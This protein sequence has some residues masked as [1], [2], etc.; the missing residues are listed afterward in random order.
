MLCQVWVPQKLQQ[1][2][3]ILFKMGSKTWTKCD[4]GNSFTNYQLLNKIMVYLFTNK[5]WTCKQR[6]RC[7][8]VVC[9]I[10]MFNPLEQPSKVCQARISHALWRQPCIFNCTYYRIININIYI[11]YMLTADK[12]ASLRYFKVFATKSVASSTQ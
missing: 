12:N 4:F 8:V 9:V 3:D 7:Y 10:Y 2:D 1:K 5:H 6:R 11:Y